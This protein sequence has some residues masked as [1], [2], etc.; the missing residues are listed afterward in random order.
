MRIHCTD[1]IVNDL[2]HLAFLDLLFKHFT[3]LMNL[4]TNRSRTQA[5]WRW[6]SS[7]SQSRTCKIK[8]NTHR[9]SL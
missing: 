8:I 4:S 7:P 5:S 9:D 3:T 6:I 1:A 2:E